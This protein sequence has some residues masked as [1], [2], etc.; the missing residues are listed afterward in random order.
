[1]LCSHKHLHLLGFFAARRWLKKRSSSNKPCSV[2]LGIESEKE[3]ASV[4]LK[5]GRTD[6]LSGSYITDLFYLL[7]KQKK[8]WD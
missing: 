6:F 8:E 2:N 4:S 3:N 5:K 1:M 7:F